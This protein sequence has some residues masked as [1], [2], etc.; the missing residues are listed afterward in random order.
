MRENRLSTWLACFAIAAALGAAPREALAK[1]VDADGDGHYAFGGGCTQSTDCNDNDPTI[2]INAPELCDGKDNNCDGLIDNGIV[3]TACDTG[4][5]G[6]CAVGM[7]QCVS[8]AT[9]C[10][11]TTGP[12]P[13]VCN[14]LDDDCNGKIDDG[15]GTDADGDGY[16]TFCDCNDADPTIHPAATDICGDGIDQDCNG[17]PDNLVLDADGRGYCLQIDSI[18]APVG[19]P[20]S[21]AIRAYHVDGIAS[22]QLTEEQTPTQTFACNGALSCAVSPAVGDY[23]ASRFLNVRLNKTPGVLASQVSKKYPFVCQ[24]EYCQPDPQIN[25]LMTWMRGKKYSECIQS[26]YLGRSLALAELDTNAYDRDIQKSFLRTRGTPNIVQPYTVDFYDIVPTDAGATSILL[27][28]GQGGNCQKSTLWPSFCPNPVPA[29]YLFEQ[30]NLQRTYGM[31]FN[32]VYHRV[33]INYVQTFGAPT[34]LSDGNYVFNILGYDSQYPHHSILHYAM[35]TY[36]GKPMEFQAV[37]GFSANTNAEPSL[38]SGA[39]IGSYSHEW[40]HTWGFRHTF[41]PGEYITIPDSAFQQLDGVMDNGYRHDTVLVDPTDPLERYA[42]EPTSGTGFIDDPTFAGTY[43]TGI[44]GTTELPA[45]GSVDP[46]ITGGQKVGSDGTNDTFELTLVNNGSVP[47]GYVMLSVQYLSN[48]ADRIVKKLDPGVPVTVRFSVPIVQENPYAQGVTF[49]LD[50]LGLI[51]ETNETNNTFKVPYPPCVD[52]DGDGFAQSCFACSNAKCP[53]Y[54]CYD[55]N[56][57]VNPSATEGPYGN[58]TCFDGLDNDCNSQV[59]LGDYKCSGDVRAVSDYS[60]GPGRISQGSYVYT[61]DNDGIYEVLQETLVNGVSRLVA[62]WRFDN[63]MPGSSHQ[64]VLNGIRS[65]NTENDNFQFYYSTDGR[66]FSI[67]P[68]AVI[69]KP[70]TNG[71]NAYT[72]ATGSLSGTVYIRVQDTN[73]TSGSQLDT[74]SIDYLVIRIVP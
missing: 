53:Q 39:G 8:G 48:F 32:F 23:D 10:V 59:D 19:Q 36:N 9:Q 11:R 28:A 73:T 6:V 14:G 16:T 44:T 34:L 7:T 12:S 24:R 70:F 62:T 26:F 25:D 20:A 63:V 58:A 71:A 3:S 27:G 37:A 41:L 66:K 42:I 5:L 74:V 72:F 43:S 18:V 60:I 51:S 47:V 1:C 4:Q 33:D 54:D 30:Q 31:S 46:A 69:S 29:D 50:R 45:C 65:G 13:E 38:G 61:R 56:A 57:S 17:N 40:G 21:V 15:P 68:N 35:Q 67:V 52:A 64:L 49:T 2:Y 55:S 22:I